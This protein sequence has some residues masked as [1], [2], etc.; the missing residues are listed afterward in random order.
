MPSLSSVGVIEPE[1]WLAIT[2][3]ILGG[4]SYLEQ[5]VIWSVGR[6]MVSQV[7]LN[8]VYTVNENLS[9]PGVPLGDENSMKDLADGFQ[10]D[11]FTRCIRFN[12]RHAWC[13]PR[14]YCPVTWGSTEL[15][16]S[17]M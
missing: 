2:L 5:M 4:G 8:T 16:K 6:S 13:N 10:C 9:M 17:S 15:T 14:R 7:L 1:V 3:H 12:F 11:A